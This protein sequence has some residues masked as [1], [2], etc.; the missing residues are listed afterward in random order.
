M[1][2]EGSEE[3]K[4]QNAHLDKAGNPG[5][6]VA[7]IRPPMA[8]KEILVNE[9]KSYLDPAKAKKNGNSGEIRGDG[10]MGQSGTERVYRI[11]L[12]SRNTD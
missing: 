9:I 3:E 6:Y 11:P 8:P 1:P 5:E 12:N 7:M 4:M 10:S 2:S